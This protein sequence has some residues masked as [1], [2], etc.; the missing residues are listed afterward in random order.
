MAA[1]LASAM[2]PAA[3]GAAS[4]GARSWHA[5]MLHPARWHA[6]PQQHRLY[7]PCLPDATLRWAGCRRIGCCRRLHPCHRC[8]RR[9]CHRRRHRCLCGAAAGAASAAASAAAGGCCRGWCSA[10]CTTCAPLSSR[11]YR[12]CVQHRQ[13]RICGW[14]HGLL[15]LPG[16]AS[17]GGHLYSIGRCGSVG[18]CMALFPFLA[19]HLCGG[20]ICTASAGAHLCV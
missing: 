9:P 17:V 3:T 10:L 18:G 4:R 20:G 11:L 6:P 7:L 2:G 8:C 16:C 1:A 5:G 12:G 13:V 14:L 15:P 19:A